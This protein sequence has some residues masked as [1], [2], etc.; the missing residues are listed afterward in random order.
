[1]FARTRYTPYSYYYRSLE[2]SSDNVPK[3]FWQPWSKIDVEVP[4]I[5]TDGD[6]KPLP[7]PGSYLVPALHGRRLFLF[8]PQITLKTVSDP[9]LSESTKTFQQIGNENARTNAPK[10]FWQVQMGW[11]EYRNGRWSPKQMSSATL[12]AAGA[13]AT[14]LEKMYP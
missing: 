4:A 5:E 11:T 14:D 10:K 12:S 2:I 6:G 1:M 3:V 13:Q 9:A 7:E 8:L